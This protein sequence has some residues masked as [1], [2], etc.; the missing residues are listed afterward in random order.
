MSS[1]GTYWCII[2]GIALIACFI[3]AKIADCEFDEEFFIEFFVESFGWITLSIVSVLGGIICGFIFWHWKIMLI[4]TIFALLILGL[5][6]WLIVKHFNKGKIF[7]EDIENYIDN[8][9]NTKYKCNNC[10]ANISKVF[11][12][13]ENGEKNYKYI[14]KYCNITYTKSDLLKQITEEIKTL[15]TKILI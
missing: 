4:I 12:V 9:N 11:E 10:G 8:E 5:I 1:M 13:N 15:S 6:I 7:D 2:A 14:C 3:H